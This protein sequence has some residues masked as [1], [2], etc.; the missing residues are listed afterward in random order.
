MNQVSR[1]GAYFET[2]SSWWSSGGTLSRSSWASRS[3]PWGASTRVGGV[4]GWW[5]AH[6]WRDLTFWPERDGCSA[7]AMQSTA[8]TV[9]QFDCRENCC[10][11]NTKGVLHLREQH[12][13]MDCTT[14]NWVECSLAEQ[15]FTSVLLPCPDLHSRSLL[16]L[17]SINTYWHYF[18]ATFSSLP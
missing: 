3:P 17:C 10:K 9:Q 5:Q 15:W 16:F 12:N 14:D 11:C 4:G 6:E 2:T 7:R 8:R 18:Q 13:L 1:V